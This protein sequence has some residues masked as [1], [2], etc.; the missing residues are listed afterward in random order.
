M[1][2]DLAEVTAFSLPYLIVITFQKLL[3]PVDCTGAAHDR[4]P[5]LF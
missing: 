2:P 5:S 4:V 1:L 3:F